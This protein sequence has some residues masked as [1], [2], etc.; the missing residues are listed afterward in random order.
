MLLRIIGG[1]SVVA[2][3]HGCVRVVESSEDDVVHFILGRGTMLSAD[4]VCGRSA[5]DVY[6]PQ[7]WFVRMVLSGVRDWYR[8]RHRRIPPWVKGHARGDDEP[9]GT[10]DGLASRSASSAAS[11]VRPRR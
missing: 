11:R 9:G 2:N 8:V 4:V 3:A 1:Q 6:D 10:V 7:G 5:L